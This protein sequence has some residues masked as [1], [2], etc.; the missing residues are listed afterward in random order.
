[1]LNECIILAGGLGTRLQSV[2]N[3]VPKVLAVVN[4]KPFLH[5]I[6]QEVTRQKISQ[7]VLSVGYKH[8]LIES[9]CKKNHSNL[10]I[11]YAIEEE[12]LGTGGGIALALQQSKSENVLI[13]NGDT[14][15]QINFDLL[16][17]LH[18]SHTACFSIALKPMKNFD[19]Y[20]SVVINDQNRITGFK[21]KQFQTEGTINAGIYLLN[22]KDFLKSRFPQKFSFEKDFMEKYYQSFNMHGFS[23]DNYFI[24]IGIPEDYYKA[25]QDFKTMFPQ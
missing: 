2:V 19:R 22:K 15:F 20:G 8:E 13:I 11:N 17:D 4:G 12:P 3:D 24:D 23:F 7:I 10:S 9:F 16:F 1:M 6:L 14:F 18:Q 21:E 5:Y 25:Q